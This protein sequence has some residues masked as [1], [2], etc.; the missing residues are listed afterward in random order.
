MTWLIRYFVTGTVT[1]WKLDSHHDMVDQISCYRDSN[2]ME[3]GQISCY[4][5]S[6]VMETGQPS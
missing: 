2:V 5:D 6:N 3:T 1:L 4:R